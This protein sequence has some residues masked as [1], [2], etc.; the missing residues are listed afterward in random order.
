MN[1]YFFAAGKR[2]FSLL[3]ITDQKLLCVSMGKEFKKICEKRLIY[4]KEL[5]KI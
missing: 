2:L 4:Q 5:C 1:K 3:I